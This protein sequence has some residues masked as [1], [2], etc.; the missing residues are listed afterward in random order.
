M[1]L[2]Y[3]T[4]MRTLMLGKAATLGAK[5]TG[6]NLA[7]V[8]GGGS[9]DSITSSDNDL[10]T[11]GFCPGMYIYTFNSTTAGNDISAGVKLVSVA[12][13]AMTF[14]TGTVNTAE[15]FAATTTVVGLWG[16]SMREILHHGIIDIFTVGSGIPATADA[17]VTGTLVSRITVASGAWVAGAFANGLMLDDAAAGAIAKTSDVWSGVGL[18]NP[19]A[20]MSFFRWKGNVTDADGADTTTYPRIQGT[21]GT[22]AS[23]NL[24]VSATTLTLAATITID[25]A[26]FTPAAYV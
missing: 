14:A 5:K 20:V 16:G 6:A 21:I 18:V 3:S 11:L 22:S 24:Q 13:G 25:T 10:I 4:A 15:A 19:S 9:A 12:A 17:A 8:D 23:Y 1:A 7:Y 2:Y 26:V